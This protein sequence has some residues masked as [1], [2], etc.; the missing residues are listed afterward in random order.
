M[1]IT[2]DGPSVKHPASALVETLTSGDDG[3]AV[4]SALPLGDYL[5]R[6]LSAPEGYLSDP[7]KSMTAELNYADQF[8]PLVWDSV[9]FENEA[10]PVELELEKV[11]EIRHQSGK[12][13]PGDGAVFGIFNAEEIVFRTEGKE[14]LLP[15]DTC[16]DTFTSDSN[17]RGILK[18]KLPEGLYYLKELKTR[19]GYI[20]DETHYCFQVS[21]DIRSNAVCLSSAPEGY[22]ADG[23]TLKSVMGDDGTAEIIADVLKSYPEKIIKAEHAESVNIL[24]EQ[25]RTR[26]LITASE[27]IPAEVLMPNGS[28]LTVNVM[29]NSFSYSWGEEHGVYVPEIAYT[30]YYA[31]CELEF[32]SEA[33]LYSAGRKEGICV[34]HTEIDGE[35]V[36]E[37]TVFMGD[38]GDSTE[39]TVFL[40]GGETWKKAY[41]GT[42]FQAETDFKGQ[43][44]LRAS[45]CADGWLETS[46]DPELLVD[47]ILTEG[48]LQ[49]TKCSTLTRQD[50]DSDVIQ[51]KINTK[52]GFILNPLKNDAEER[53]WPPEEPESEEPEEPAPEEPKDESPEEPEEPK[54]DRPEEPSQEIRVPKTGDGSGVYG[55]LLLVILCL[56]AGITAWFA[57][58]KMKM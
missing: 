53:N 40:K 33:V 17:G 13:S 24:E 18:A 9:T 54:E 8:T 27:T 4:S 58:R 42:V 31:E 35:P 52:D 45:G 19:Y 11:F 2:A 6:E 25:E 51:I 14:N 39:E 15:A 28:L 37:C 29:E 47:G 23:I 22:D 32:E 55:Y 38:Y 48:K 10:V 44:K 56:T 3:T 46:D 41:N 16:L 50:S 21:D 57:E 49:L 30:G 43:V 36:I 1:N 26:Y 7:A 12:Y 5:V 34:K 20:L